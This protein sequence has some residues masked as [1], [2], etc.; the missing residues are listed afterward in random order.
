MVAYLL[1]ELFGR[2]LEGNIW[3]L[4]RIYRY[5]IVGVFGRADECASISDVDRK[6]RLCHAKICASGGDDIGINF[7][8][9]YGDVTINSRKLARDSPRRQPCIEIRRGQKIVPVP[10]GQNVIG[11]VDRM[12]G[13]PLIQN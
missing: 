6:I 12:D 2:Q 7:D 1:K 11:A 9:I 8:A 3:L 10:S 5:H 13:L 4:K